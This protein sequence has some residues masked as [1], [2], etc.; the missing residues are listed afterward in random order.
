MGILKPVMVSTDKGLQLFHSRM[1][2][3]H[4]LSW[5]NLQKKIAFFRLFSRE[6]S[7]T[8][9]TPK[10]IYFSELKNL[11]GGGVRDSPCA[12]ASCIYFPCFYL[13]ENLRLSVRSIIVPR[14]PCPHSHTLRMLMIPHQILWGWS[15]FGIMVHNHVWF[16][17]CVLILSYLA[18]ADVC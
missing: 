9:D 2:G 11:G 3:C 17:S 10:G 13:Y 15:L 12:Y 14:I 16:L 8:C 4:L 6:R 5:R 1:V 18:W 7:E